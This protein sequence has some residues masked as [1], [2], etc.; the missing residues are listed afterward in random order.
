MAHYAHSKRH[1]MTQLYTPDKC[2]LYEMVQYQ[3]EASQH[4]IECSPFVRLFL[5]CAGM[6][7]VEVTP[8]YDQHGD[9]LQ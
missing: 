4:Q 2:K 3:C 9:P 6:P 5:R 8:E 1:E 7:M